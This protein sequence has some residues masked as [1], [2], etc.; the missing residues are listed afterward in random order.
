MLKSTCCHFLKEDGKQ[1]LVSSQPNV[2]PAP[3][4]K[5]HTTSLCRGKET[6][7]PAGRPVVLH[8]VLQLKL[9]QTQCPD[10]SDPK[11]QATQSS[12]ELH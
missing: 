12:I 11:D 5:A 9:H 7:G 3:V 1:Q 4:L 8:L 6:A 10:G 2:A